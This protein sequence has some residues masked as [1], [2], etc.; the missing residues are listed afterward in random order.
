MYKAFKRENNYI[1]DLFFETF[2]AWLYSMCGQDCETANELDY[3]I[4]SLKQWLEK[5]TD[6]SSNL[7]MKTKDYLLRS[8]MPR[9]DKLGQCYFQELYGGELGSNSLSEQENSALKRDPMG[10][11]NN[12][13]INRAVETVANHTNRRIQGL[14]QE[15]LRSLSQMPVEDEIDVCVEEPFDT[16]EITDTDDFRVDQN[17]SKVLVDFAVKNVLQQHKSSASYKFNMVNDQ[18]FYVRRYVW[19]PPKAGSTFFADIPRFDRT[20]VVT[21]TNSKFFLVVS[22][23]FNTFVLTKDFVFPKECLVCSCGHFA[24]HGIPC[25]HIY[26]ILQRAPKVTDC[27]VRHMKTYEVFFG[28]DKN[29]TKIF[30]E[31]LNSSLL[32]PIVGETWRTENNS[33]SSDDLHWFNE[34]LRLIV[35][36]PGIINN[37]TMAS[38]NGP[39]ITTTTAYASPPDSPN[40][41]DINRSDDTDVGN[42]FQSYPGKTPFGNLMPKYK[43]ICDII[44]NTEDLSMARQAF[45]KLYQDLVEKKKK[46]AKDGQMQSLPEI[47]SGKKQK[48]LA[49]SSSPSKWKSH[50]G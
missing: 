38:E 42:I 6:V 2:I 36:R 17:M 19:S 14:R 35:L 27:N 4:A 28:K 16:D 29:F 30:L 3:S 23:L 10:P 5:Q 12:A 41:F 46:R 9:I 13:G 21:I 45:D 50:V 44:Q 47:A 48:R 34:A 40:N 31:E 11:R 7:Q 32:G 20:R 43:M 18:T 33:R 22:C 25:R 15:A 37:N 8:F 24:R 26:C 1:D 49:P 39:R